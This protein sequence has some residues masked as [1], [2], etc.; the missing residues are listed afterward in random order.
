MPLSDDEQKILSQIEQ[1]L[2]ETDPDL[3]NEVATTTVYTHAARNIKWSVLGFIIG[4]AVI[5]LTL[6]TSFW[7]AFLGFAIMLAAALYFEQNMRKL[8]KAGMNQ[9]SMRVGSGGLRNAAERNPFLRRLRPEDPE[10]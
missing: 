6:S 5:V 9:L 2:H 8:G 4:L 7:L 10:S 3:A 1:Q